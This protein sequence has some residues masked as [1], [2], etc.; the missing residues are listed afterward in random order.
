MSFKPPLSSPGLATALL[1]LAMLTGCATGPNVIANRAP[2]LDIADYRSF[3]FMEPL[4]TDR[5]GVRT[6]LSNR[7]VDAAR[8][9]LE[10]KG[11]VHA[12]EQPDLLVNFVV[13]TRETLSGRPSSSVNVGFRTGGYSTWGGYSVGVG[14]STADVVQQTEG[15]LVIDIV[16]A[17]SNTLVWEG[18]LSGRITDKVRR[19]L[20]PAIDKAVVDILSEFP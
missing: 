20:D 11:L 2:G 13:S 4:S 14:T 3:G 9:E 12:E 19:N 7:L 17:G 16:D 10:Q 15:T 8:R 1:V 18:A 6:L 5:D